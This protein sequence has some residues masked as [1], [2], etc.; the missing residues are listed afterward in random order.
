MIF[1][2][3]DTY[4]RGMTIDIKNKQQ[5]GAI[6]G[7]KFKR[8]AWTPQ[9]VPLLFSIYVPVFGEPY[10]AYCDEHGLFKSGYKGDK[11]SRV[12]QGVLESTDI[13]EIKKVEKMETTINT[14]DVTVTMC[15]SKAKPKWCAKWYDVN[16]AE[17][18]TTFYYKKKQAL[19]D[20]KASPTT[21]LVLYKMNKIITVDMPLKIEDV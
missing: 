9:S 4:K 5:I 21:T 14:V 13:I 10:F 7:K 12:G 20:L 6:I 19:I 2:Y 16:G 17:I 15:E 11:F 8:E 1:R 18:Q 3:E